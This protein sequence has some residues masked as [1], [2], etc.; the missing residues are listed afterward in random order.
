VLGDLGRVTLCLPN[1]PRRL[2]RFPGPPPGLGLD[3]FLN[4]PRWLR[5]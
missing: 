5:T 1:L 3:D 2:V 4:D